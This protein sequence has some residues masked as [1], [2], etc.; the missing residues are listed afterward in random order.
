LRHQTP[1]EVGK[2]LGV[3]A[4]TLFRAY[5]GADDLLKLTREL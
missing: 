4:R 3:L 1:E 2:I 5:A